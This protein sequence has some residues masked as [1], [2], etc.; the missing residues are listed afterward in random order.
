MAEYV[1]NTGS[2][3]RRTIHR[4][5]GTSELIVFDVDEAIDL[6]PEEIGLLRREID[7]GTLRPA[8]V[9]RPRP[10]KPQRAIRDVSEVDFVDPPR[11]MFESR[12]RRERHDPDETPPRRKAWIW[13]RSG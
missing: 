9:D 5:D 11:E 8:A 7:A 2:V 10:P 13:P 6:S 1:T 12:R 4:A 3:F